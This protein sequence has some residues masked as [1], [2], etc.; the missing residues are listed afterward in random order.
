[1]AEGSGPMAW[2]MR[3]MHA[4]VYASRLR[5]LVRQ[6]VPHLGADDRVLDVGCGSGALGQAIMQAPDLPAGVRV[7]GLERVRRGNELIPVTGYDGGAIPFADRSF[8]VVILADV[9]HHERE[10]HRLLAECARVARRLLIV[11]DHQ[12]NGPF[13]RQRI[14]L[15]DWAANAP[16]G[17]PCLY[18]YNTPAQWP[19]WFGRHG[20]AIVAELPSMHL[21][22]APY[23]LLF[24]RRLQYMAIL[25]VSSRAPAVAPS[26]AAAAAESQ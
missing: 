22:P 14:S 9:L 21:Y 8:D 20:L 26:E 3:R 24:G 23:N 17:V 7:E 13:A 5:E 25:S 16:F 1:M 12:I 2:L 6:I 15:I 4:P 18:Q 10:P 19:E 11:K